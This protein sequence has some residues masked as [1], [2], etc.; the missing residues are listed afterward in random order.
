M[1]LALL[2]YAISLLPK[3][4]S[5]MVIS[6]IVCA[7]ATG[8][9]FIW[10]LSETDRKSYYSATEND[11]REANGVMCIKWI[12]RVIVTGFLLS[13][14]LIFIPSEKTA[15]TMVGAYA[16]Q[17]VAE[18]DKVQAM[19][20]KVLTIIEQKLDSYIDDGLKEAEDK[21]TKKEKRK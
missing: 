21:V 18:N 3:I 1:D 15:Y 11:Q 16:A 17:K 12:K 2:V 9:F 4:G 5:F 10:Y 19:S 8:F 20:G 14:F 7:G 13:F 6:I